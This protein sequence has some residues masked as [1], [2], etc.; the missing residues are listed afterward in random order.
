MGVKLVGT[1][2]EGPTVTAIITAADMIQAVAVANHQ[3]LRSYTVQFKIVDATDNEGDRCRFCQDYLNDTTVYFTD[4]DHD[5][6]AED[7]C[8]FCALHLIDGHFD[9]DPLYTVTVEMGPA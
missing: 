9:V 8:R 2:T 4:M 6:H 3:V 5:T 7:C 1:Q